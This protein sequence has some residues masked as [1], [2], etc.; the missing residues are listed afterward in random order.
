MANATTVAP[1]K[2]KEVEILGQL[3][4][5]GSNEHKYLTQEFDVDKKYVYELAEKNME[6]EI[7]V[8]ESL[9][10]K[11]IMTTPFKSYQNVV[12]S[13]Q[14]VWN[15]SRINIRYYD[16]CETIFVPQQPKDK[17]TIDD[18]IKRTVVRSFQH[19]KMI[20][21]GYDK[22]LLLYLSICGWNV[23]SPFRT[24]SASN[25][26]RP[27]DK[28]KISLAEEDKLDRIIEAQELAK[29]ASEEKMRIHGSYLGIYML[30]EDSGNELTPHEIRIK[31][32]KKASEDAANFIATYGNKS[33]EVKYYI[34]KALLE[35][36][37]HN[38]HNPNKVTWG[39]GNT[40]IC[41]IS[42]IR[43]H[44]AIAERVY[45]FSQTEAG[46]EFCNQLKALYN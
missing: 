14:I 25:I 40:E 41:D 36:K 12:F 5:E 22:M 28:V 3:V 39:S 37:I 29:K 16:G 43:S 1:S 24:R 33:I 8:F 7:P 23:D 19:G 10:L 17:D 9:S 21:E 31:Y 46:E 11:P 2:P 15:G 6:R 42:G 13:S 4:K 18:L 20:V 30:D 35:G 27:V 26:F 45:E 34:N 32:R 38:K 44:D